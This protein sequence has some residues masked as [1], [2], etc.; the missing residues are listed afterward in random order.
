MLTIVVI[1]LWLTMLAARGTPIG[2]L[3]HR[4]LVATPARRLSQ[5]ER[6]H[7]LLLSVLL[8]I[9]IVSTLLF[10]EEARVMLAFGL[11]DIAALA[12]A[13][14]LGTLLDVTLVAVAAASVVRV[15]A[16]TGRL[17]G[18]PTPR[19][20]RTRAVRIRREVPPANDDEDRPALAA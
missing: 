10:A 12:A 11:P 8:G 16:V 6:S 7:M 18:R 14:D 15:R 20:P 4:W 17:R 19:R 2:R 13:L 9:V 1:G 5:I 3:L